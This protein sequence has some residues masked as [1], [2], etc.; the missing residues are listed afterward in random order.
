MFFC[1]FLM[2]YEYGNLYKGAHDESNQIRNIYFI[3]NKIMI[4]ISIAKLLL[5]GRWSAQNIKILTT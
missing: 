2:F 4:F 3:V 5:A 1:Y